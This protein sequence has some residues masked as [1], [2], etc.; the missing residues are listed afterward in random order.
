MKEPSPNN[1]SNQF[2]DRN[3]GKTKSNAIE[4]PSISLPKGG[5]AIKGIDEK[6]SVNAVNGTAGFSIPLP[7]SG[8]R[9]FSP[10]LGIAYSSGAGN[11]IFGLGWSLGIASIKRKTDKKLPE[12]FDTIDSDTFLLSD[13][14]DLV[15]EFKKDNNGAFIKDASEDYLL[16]EFERNFFGAEYIIKTY[17]PRIEGLFSRIERWTEKKTGY[18]H[19]RIVS[20]NNITSLFG[21]NTESR[22]ADPADDKRIFEWLLEFSFDDKGNCVYYEYKPEND[23]GLPHTLHNK[24]RKDSNLLY[25]NTYLK[26]VLYGIRTPYQNN[27]EIYS[28]NKS[29]YFFENV[30]DYGEH[31]DLNASF[32]EVKEWDFRTDAF[33]EYRPGFEIR[34]TRLCKRVLLY[35]H[36]EELTNGTAL[37][38]STDFIYSDNGMD[39][40]TFLKEV[41]AKGYIKDGDKYAQKSMPPFSFEYQKHEW[42]TT[43]KSLNTEALV[44]APTGIN[45]GNYHFV[46]LFNE[47][48]SGIL[49][50][51]GNG[52]YYKSNLGG[53]NFSSAQLI[54]AKPSFQGL[55]QQVQLMDLEANGIKQLVQLN[56]EPKGYFE[57]S[58]DEEWQPF[59][60]LEDMPNIS[61]DAYSRMLD[62]NGDGLADILLSEP[63]GFTWYPSK[64]KNGYETSLKINHSYDEELAPAIVFA[65]STQSIF[66]SDMSGDGL[67][68]IVRI[69]NNGEI[70]YWPNLGYAR[71]GA[72]VS[73]D[74]APVFDHCDN[75][76]PHYIKIADIDGSGTGDIIYLGKNKFSIYLNRQGNSFAD[77]ITIDPFPEINNIID[78]D[79]TD[80]LGTGLSCIVWNSPLA[81]DT[82]RPTR[83][84]D[85]MNSKKPHVM[86]SYKNNF[87]KEVTMEY[88]PSTVFYIDD[89]SADKPW[90]TKLHFP[91]H[92]VSKSETID[93]VTDL[94]FTNKY[95]YHHGYYD[96]VEREFRGFGMV[97]QIDTEEYE[98]L[99]N[100]QASNATAIEFHEPPVL[101]KTWYHTG[102]YLQNKKIL[103]YFKHE[104][105]YN[106][107]FVKKQFGDL[108]GREAALPDAVFIGDL[109]TQELVEAHRACKGMMLRQETFA[110]D[111]SEKEKIPYAVATHNCHIKLLQSRNKNKFAVFLPQESEAINFSYER[112]IDDPRIA[113]S[114]NLEI[115]DLG[116]I[117]KA[118][119]VVYPRKSRPIELSEDKIWDEQNRLHIILT[120]AGFTKDILTLNTYRLRLPYQTKTFELKLKNGLA[121]NKL[122][123]ITD[124][125]IAA[126]ELPYE[127]VFTPNS[128]EKR[129]I[130]HIKTIYLKND[131]LTPMDEGEHDTLGFNLESYQLALTTSLL[132]SIYKKPTEVSKINSSMLTEGKYVDLKNDGHWWIRSGTIGYINTLTGETAANAANRFYLP[133]SYIDPF[134]SITS[135]SY[136]KDY[137]LFI[138]NTKDALDN[139]VG[140]EEFDLRTLS[141][142][143]IKDVNGNLTEV[144][145]DALGLVVGTVIRGKGNEGDLLDNFE[146]DLTATQIQNFFNDPLTLGRDLLRQATTRL[147]YDFAKI[148]CSIGTIVREEHGN[149]NPNSKLQYSFEY[150]GG[151]GKVILKK[152]QA[153]PGDAPH[154]DPDG[155][156]VKQPNGELDLQPAP[157]RW[158]GNG[159]TILNNKGKPIKQYEPYFSG[160]HLYETEPELREA[161]VTPILHY[162]AAGRLVKTIMPD[163]TF[164][165][166]EYDSWMQKSFDEND[167]CKMSKWYTDRINRNIDSILLKQG[168][169]PI[170][171]KEAAEKTAIHDTT[172]SVVYTDS[173]GRPFYTIAHNK[174]SDFTTDTIK[175]EF[176]VTQA[177]LDIEGNLRTV[178]DARNNSVMEYKYDMLG[179][180]V[181]QKS[182]DAG[183]RWLLNDSTEKPV[184]AWDSKGQRFETIYDKLHR[185][186]E[187]SVTKLSTA[188]V[189]VFEKFEYVDTK[190]LTAAQL[191]AQQAK[192]LIGKVITHYDTAGIIRLVLCDFKGNTLESSRELCSDYKTIP[193]W[194]TPASITMEPEVFV[195]KSEFD[196]LNRPVKIYTPHTPQIP[197]TVIS[198]EYNEANL[199]NAVSAKLRGSSQDT[200]FVRNIDYDAKGQRISILYE[201]NTITKYSYDPKTFRLQN[202]FT[203]RNFGADKLQD[204]SY[205]YDPVGNI[206]FI[207]DDA[208]QSIFFKNTRVD[209]DCDYVY[210]SIYRLI[211]AKGREHIA[212]NTA[213]SAYDSL[214]TNLPHQGDSQQLQQYTQ[215]YKYDAVGNMLLMQNVNSWSRTFTYSNTN[216]QLLTAPSNNELGSP[217]TYTYDLHGSMNAMPHLPA[218][219]WN[220]KDQ[221]QQIG[222]T[223]SNENDSTNQAYYVYD[224]T[225]ER[226]RKV[227]VKNN[228]TEERIYLGGF[229]IF[230]KQKNGAIELERETLHIM[231]GTKRI[232]LIDTKIKPN[233]DAEIPLIRYQYSNHLGTASL[234]L[235]GSTTAQIISYEE[236]YPYG[237]TSYQAT[238]QLR[239]VPVKRYRYTGKERDEESG[240][241][242][243]SARYYAP[244]LGRWMSTDP[245]LLSDGIN[246][247]RYASD[248]PV[249][250]SDPSGRYG[251]KDLNKDLGR[252]NRALAMITAPTEGPIGALT[253]A[254]MVKATEAIVG[255]STPVDGEPGEKLSTSQRKEAAIDA[256]T[257][258]LP[259]G[260]IHMESKA[261]GQAIGNAIAGKTSKAEAA[262]IAD[263]TGVIKNTFNAAESLDKAE[264]ASNQGHT[265]EA[266][267]NYIDAGLSIAET[268]V[269]TI[270]IIEG[271]RGAAK[272]PKGGGRKSPS[273]SGGDLQPG[274]PAGYTVLA[275]VVLEEQPTRGSRADHKIKAE[276]GLKEQ[277]Q[278]QRDVYKSPYRV[279]AIEEIKDVPEPIRNDGPAKTNI[280][281]DA[282]EA[283]KNDSISSTAWHH[284]PFKEGLMQLIYR[285]EHFGP[286]LHP[287]GRGGFSRWLKNF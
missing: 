115:D 174:F 7:V 78:V 11:G 44:H 56:N 73:L 43:V 127:A 122:F 245:A 284:H 214:R 260:S 229:E 283:L 261:A 58:P 200:F 199:L 286:L 265:G 191:S 133:Q 239:E 205:T 235:D 234:E 136:Y 226:I 160:S 113:H 131:L 68:D 287:E 256:V 227:V 54:T 238:D 95:V 51:E 254:V 213:P 26:R 271:I 195:S 38:K 253:K 45:S 50:E 79:M 12:Y 107:A 244:W 32:N 203:T 106:D 176:Y 285:A 198:P 270:G 252:V 221:L 92:C 116:N 111:G 70:C 231:D 18:I 156:L 142:K 98:Y 161:G 155:K 65:D 33:S 202:L 9:G 274:K 130:E 153:E 282:P 277:V 112:N 61:Q 210:D 183:E 151:L 71:F 192:N 149:V 279:S 170:K 110:L 273:G 259:G 220:F 281:L 211:Q 163:D 157:H 74:N 132:D 36:F 22:I 29:D 218:M 204:L 40:F 201:N 233:H 138:Q 69:K 88:T 102:A 121:A 222:I 165:S 225:G 237:S 140:V 141:P 16:N 59:K 267:G 14:E 258:L 48:L 2:L 23:Q 171:E 49:T 64:G 209:P 84:I 76:N 236:Y 266:V 17:R 137:Y 172:P 182:M 187:L 86:I 15:P 243:H 94:R 129:L 159:R 35:H 246:L 255:K 150:S 31:D 13:A 57:L 75:F 67:I 55:N 47:G 114:L 147:V 87:G 263:P 276:A 247:Y 145:I 52:W 124:L 223:A 178:I 10:A 3:G 219:S 185:P 232:V 190:D 6:F 8:A 278:A 91:V 135:V 207:K 139:S 125:N 126:T 82:L 217:V 148:P 275:E 34:T 194:K 241:E 154:R 118:A 1:P 104:Y 85:L 134:G 250:L 19:W 66:L 128:D 164:S 240:L 105:W 257:L 189:T 80:L 89:K 184:F 196:A 81:K 4:I 188:A 158:V 96:H 212:D 175:E 100:A 206:T 168:K 262:K 77:E 72:K 143:I 186:V 39:G 216:N 280:P 93:R 166:T 224:A 208:L 103:D 90:V 162:D 169:D 21:K 117:L 42:N 46:D 30:F 41:V 123:S 193:D 20:K 167:N 179:H 269:T 53:G 180:Q 109:T 144:A 60:A 173:L 5:G 230:R 146:A 181:Y 108:S 27:G 37:V 272:G 25:T 83:Y 177:I 24:N 62:L 152:I 197:A 251:L 63:N 99:K 120:E 228:V 268:I 248:N 97:E 28:K 119:A 242:Y 264:V 249:G 215:R 101:T